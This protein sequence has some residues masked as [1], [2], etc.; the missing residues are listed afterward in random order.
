MEKKF[1]LVLSMLMLFVGLGVNA[2]TDMT[3]RISDPDFEQEGRSQ[4]KTNSFGRQGNSDFKLKHGNYYREVWS[5]GTAGDS[6]IYQD[7]ANM[8]VG[9]YTMTMT[10]QNI[11]QSAPSQVCTGTWIYANDQKTNFNVPG[12]YTVTCVVIDGNLRIGAEVK[13]CTGNYV[14]IDN[15]RLSYMQLT[16]QHTTACLQVTPTVSTSH[17]VLAGAQT[18]ATR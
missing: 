15:V 16:V 7:L 3:Y 17:S 10:C 6:Y 5:G 18:M 1:Y 11:K 8:P 9:T 2:Q 14:C 4:W 13:N 12:D